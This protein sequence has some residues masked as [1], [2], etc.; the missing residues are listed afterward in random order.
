MADLRQVRP[1][2]HRA[3]TGPLSI[4]DGP[5]RYTRQRVASERPPDDRLPTAP[6]SDSWLPAEHGSDNRNLQRRVARGASWTILDNWGRQLLQLLVFVI[7]ARLL[8][9]ADFGLVALAMVFVALAQLFVDQGLG[10]ALVQRRELTKAHVDTAFWAALALGVV[11][12]VV[13]LLA[14]GPIAALLNEPELQP[15]LQALSLVFILSGLAAIPMAILQRE[16]RFRSLALRTIF[17]LAG[18]GALGIAMALMGYGVW[19]LVGQQLTTGV[20]SVV[21]L[22]WASPWRPG[23]TFSR[24]H[25]RELIGFGANVVGSDL[26]HYLTRYSDKFLVG[27]VLGTVPLGIY[28]VGYRILDA[29]SALLVGIARKISFPALARVQHEP[30]R[31]ARAY[32]RM[33]RITA[34]LVLPGYIGLALVAPE[35]IRLVF[36]ARWAE[37]GPVA[38]VLFL[39][40]PAFAVQGFGGTLLNAAG[41]PDITLRLRFVSAAMTVVGFAIAVPFGLLAVAAAYAIR[42]YLMLPLQLYYQ[43]KYAGIPTSEYLLRLRGPALATA[44]M[45]AAVLAVKWLLLPRVDY[46]VLLAAEVTVGAVVFLA[47]AWVLERELVGE[48][49]NIAAQA[50]PG[51]ERARRRLAKRRA[52]AGADDEGLA[53]DEA[54]AEVADAL[55]ARPDE[56]EPP[57]DRLSD[58]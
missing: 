6:P 39:V 33:T 8:V 4:R 35:L 25:F 24:R 43:R 20:L 40:G 13:G 51:G 16:L 19:A 30:E 37:A 14:A 12:A 21:A 57:R 27:T 9:P 54:A 15:V 5:R 28:A 48:V 52:A 29:A 22:W 7:I 2:E 34:A 45:A 55:R 53:D 23:L 3:L 18:G 56:L 42:G 26:L 17:S 46:V 58:F 10:D 41:R 36:G 32:F 44:V 31:L 1:A 11:L 50:L 47:A 38:A 49:V